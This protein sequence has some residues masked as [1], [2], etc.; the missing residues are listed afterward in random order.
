MKRIAQLILLLGGLYLTACENSE[1]KTSA[2]LIKKE[3]FETEILTQTFSVKYVDE[4]AVKDSVN[5]LQS[6]IVDE[7]GKELSNIFYNL[8]GTI[9]WKD[10][11]KYD[12]QGNKIGSDYFENGPQAISYYEYDLDSLGRKIAYRAKDSNTDTLLYDGASRYENDGT[13]RKDGYVDKQGN[14]KWNYEY[15]FDKNGKELSYTYISSKSGKRFPRTYEYITHN[16]KGEWTE[17]NTIED[18]KVISIE[19]R[20]FKRLD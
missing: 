8:D 18:G 20:S 9:A 19:T 12:E 5:M 3:K 7:A 11:Y 10:Q 14:F 13:L 17:R 2:T 4:V 16:E 1:P 15:Y 6:I